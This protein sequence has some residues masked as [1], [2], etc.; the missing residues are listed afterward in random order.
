MTA[1]IA[2][3]DT[4][5]ENLVERP[6]LFKGRLVRAILAG[7][8]TQ[9]RRTFKR[10]RIQ[11]RHDVESDRGITGNRPILRAPAGS[12]H[13]AQLNQHGAVSIFIEGHLLGIKPDEF[14]FLC[15]YADGHTYLRRAP[16]VPP[17]WRIRPNAGSRLW[18]RES[19]AQDAV[20]RMLWRADGERD[21]RWSPS[22]HLPRYASRI[23]LEVVDE[24][25]LEKLHEITEEDAKAEGT[26]HRIAPGG[27]L[28]GAF[29]HVDKPINHR[30]FFEQGW[31]EING[32]E[33]WDLNPWVW[34]VS[35]RRVR[36]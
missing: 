22:I 36:P 19:W 3:R 33:S 7:S 29:D 2:D 32:A 6:I 25:R 14:D 26:A 31:R 30:A 35:F 24:I 1:A 8:K 12:R 34:V 28:A 4:K 20:G 10:L 13:D 21:V 16:G 5:P 18:V 9:T 27:D 23:D 11:L 15:P 17:R